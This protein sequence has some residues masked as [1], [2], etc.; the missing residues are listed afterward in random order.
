MQQLRVIKLAAPAHEQA[1]QADAEHQESDADHDAERPEHQTDLGPVL[2][3]HGIEAVERRIQRMLE[4]QRRG[5]RNLDGIFHLRFVLIGNAEQDQRC[6]VGMALE[7]AFHRHH[8]DGLVLQRVEAVLVARENLD[9]RD[10][11]RHP[12]RHGEHHARA[13]QPRVPEQVPRADAT[14]HEGGGEIGRE[15]HVHEAIGEGRIEDHLPPVRGDELSRRVHGEARGRLHP[16]IGR[17]NPERGNQRADGDHQGREEMQLVADA[18]QPEQ[19]Y[20]EESRLEKECGEHFI[21]HQRADHGAG[22]VGEHRPVGAE[23]IRHHDAGNDAHAEGDGENL[24]PVIEEIDEDFAA[25]P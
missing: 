25:G 18:L 4:D 17:E 22:L 2:A 24:Q 12:H 9:R 3:R 20:A 1:E 16:G 10:N 21:G 11:G 7:V 6:A 14:N 23:L 19:H 8:L 15:H 5:F 13:F